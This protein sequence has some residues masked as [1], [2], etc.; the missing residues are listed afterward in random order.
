MRLS[1]LA[2]VLCLTLSLLAPRASAAPRE[3][4]LPLP[5]RVDLDRVRDSRVVSALNQS[6]GDGLRVSTSSTSLVLH[7]DVDKLPRSC[8]S[9]SKAVRTFTAAA[10]PGA[11]AAQAAEYGLF[12]PRAFDPARPLVVLV[13]GLDCDG[14]NWDDMAALLSAEGHQVACFNYPSDQPVADSAALLGREMIALRRR[15]PAM[16]TDLL[17]HSMGCLVSRAYVEGPDYAGGVGRLV[18]V[19]PPNHGSDWARARLLLEA[20]EHYHLWRHDPHWRPS[21]PITDGLGEAG[22]DLRPGSAFLKQ[23]NARPRRAGVRYTIVAG[24]QTPTRRVTA[25][26][27]DATSD[28]IGGRAASWW[29]L[30][31]C[32]SKLSAAADGDGPVKIA[33]ARLAGVDDFVIV[34]S[35]HAGLYFARGRTPPAAWDTVRDR[36]SR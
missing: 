9:M 1:N 12:L 20:D 33:S 22:R 19:A 17:A 30:R 34:S 2:A 36:L 25:R 26:C 29:G 18:L 27:L 28:S 31:Q 14:A 15:F 23:L 35:D 3:A 6:L 16:P 21:W 8:Q 7:F 13:H 4:R 10:A 5:G 32:K 11:T 24:S